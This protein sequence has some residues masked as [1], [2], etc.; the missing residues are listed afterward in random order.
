MGGNHHHHHRRV[1]P[2][3]PEALK[4]LRG[5]E[6]REREAALGSARW[7]AEVERSLEIGLPGA[8]SIEDK[9]IS[10]FSRTE[11]PHF[12]GINTFMSF[13]YLE[14]VREVGNYDVAILGAPFDMGTTYRSG[15]RFGPQAIRRISALYSTYNYEFAVDLRESLKVADLGDV[16]VIPANIEK[17]FDQIANAVSHVV[18][19]GVFPVILGGDHSIG[20]PDVRGI[21]PHIDGNIGIIHLD[22]HVDIQEKDMDERMHTTPWFHATNI[23]N[24]P[25][26]NLVQCGIGGW[27]VPRSGVTVARERQTTIMTIGDVE[28]MGIEKAAEM[29]LE[30]AWDGA[31]AVYLSFDIDSVDGGLVPGTGWPEPGGYLPREALKFLHLVAKEG[32]CGM[33]VVEVSPPYD[34]SDTTALLAARAVADVLATLVTEGHLGTYPAV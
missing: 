27:Q 20:Y 2:P 10:T 15:T 6:A 7:D 34:T 13:P 1:G 14:D 12:A 5:Y 18:E 29:A 4:R 32:L 33:E 31:E 17:T 3:D 16:F 22:R 23:P 25:P 30:V 11:L 24:A 19:S 21:A 28:A 26:K 9:T 8:D